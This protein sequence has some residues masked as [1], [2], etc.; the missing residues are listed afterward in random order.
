MWERLASL[1]ILA[2]SLCLGPIV[3]QTAEGAQTDV[4]GT[5]VPGRE[6][7][8]VA[9]VEDPAAR[10]E[11][12][13]IETAPTV[14]FGCVLDADGAPRE[15]AM[16]TSS[17][18]GR[19]LTDA[20][21]EFQLEVAVP[22]DASSVQ[23]TAVAGGGSLVAS[24][25]VALTGSST[26]PSGTL[27]LLQD[28]GCQPSWVPTFGRPPGFN[29]TVWAATVFDDG[30]GP[31]LYAAGRYVGKWDGTRWSALGSVVS[32]I[33]GFALVSALTV[34]DDGSGPALYAG[35][36]FT[37]VAGVAAS[38]VAKWD[39]TRWSAL[40]SGMYD[41]VSALTVYDDGSGPALYAGGG[42]TTAGGVM[43][44]RI[45][46][47]DGSSWS[48]LGT[49][50]NSSVAVLTVYDDGSGPALYAGAVFPTAGLLDAHPI[51]KWDGTSWSALGT[52]MNN[53]VDAL[54]VY[55][56]GSGPAL[57]AGGGFTNAGGVMANRIAKWDGSS[58][59][60]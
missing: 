24:A 60:A 11:T 3:A 30:S 14:L 7:A 49:G 56:A 46:K 52:G 44:N 35:G 27:L 50:M 57:Y 55:D 16:V 34:Y 38:V 23:V 42:F 18:G 31:A 51:A 21:G 1:S 22:L 20:R 5:A 6:H 40:G 33:Y 25:P 54:T 48:A 9:G 4:R 43:A 41:G 39:G 58:W 10:I 17:A 15:G 36:N 37:E 19:T 53:D 29:D 13:Q 47:W 26:T 59:S 45:A 8:L 28:G 12:A 2:G 32:S